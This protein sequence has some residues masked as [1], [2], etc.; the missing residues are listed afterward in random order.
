MSYM[1]MM[2]TASRPNR[3]VV[4]MLLKILAVFVAAAVLG[5]YAG[6]LAIDAHDNT[7]FWVGMACFA[8]TI[9]IVFYGGLWIAASVRELLG[10]RMRRP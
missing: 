10:D 1:P 9:I 4:T 7:L 8:A 3:A 2:K 5:G 6:P